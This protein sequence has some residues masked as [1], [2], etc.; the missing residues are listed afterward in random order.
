MADTQTFTKGIQDTT[1]QL[2]NDPRKLL[3]KATKSHRTF[4][5]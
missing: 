1:K 5:N 2:M 3:L 4:S